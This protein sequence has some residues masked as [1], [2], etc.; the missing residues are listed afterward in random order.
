M[1]TVSERARPSRVWVDHLHRLRWMIRGYIFLQGVAAFLSVLAILFWMSLFV[2]WAVEPS[3]FVRTLL[4]VIFCAIASVVV[5]RVAASRLLIPLSERS[6]ALL[7]ERHYHQLGERLVTVVE[8]SERDKE[9]IDYDPRMLASTREEVAQLLPDANVRM[10]FSLRPLLQT[11]VIAFA[12]LGSVAVFVLWQPGAARIWAD[13]SL[14]LGDSAWPHATK[15]DVEGFPP[16]P[17]GRRSVKVAKGDSLT[18]RAMA[19]LN[20]SVPQSVEISYQ[21][22]GGGFNRP[23]M[24]RLNQAIPGR[25]AHQFYEYQFTDIQASVPF[26]VTAKGSGL[27]SKSDRV[28]GLLIEAV[29]SPDLTEISMHYEY[30]QYLGREAT[31]SQIRLSKPAPEGTGV[32]ILARSSKPLLK[33]SF[34][35]TDKETEVPW[36]SIE[37]HEHDSH[38]IELDLGSLRDD[39]RVSFQLVDTDGVTNQ[40]TIQ[41]LVRILP[42]EK[43]EVDVDLVGIGKAITPTA[44]LPIRGV[45]Q[46]DYGISKSWIEFSIDGAGPQEQEFS[47]PEN[48]QLDEARNLAFEL[49]DGQLHAGQILSLQIAA[50]DNCSLDPEFQIGKSDRFRLRVVSES[51]LRALLETRERILRRRFEAILTELHRTEDSFRRMLSDSEETSRSSSDLKNETE[52]NAP[53]SESENSRGDSPALTR[54]D[55]VRLLRIETAIQT[56]D[57]MQHETASVAEEFERILAELKNNKVAFFEEL[58]RRI[59]GGIVVPLNQIVEQQFS[60]F[61]RDLK[62]LRHALEDQQSLFAEIE[63]S[64]QQLSKIIRALENVLKNMLD[65]QKFNELLADLRKII[66]GHKQVSKQTQEQRQLLEK[67]LKEQLKKGLLDGP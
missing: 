33:A 37:I 1:A 31:T 48:G 23:N 10:V 24:T 58:E 3:Q 11:F 29:E 26:S 51:D 38:A 60:Q 4:L 14:L 5:Y 52:E 62:R 13:R 47:L 61:D 63:S 65:L 25:D 35:K 9:N 20:W 6:L 21:A 56:S 12:V 66:H 54:A 53:E 36:E 64:Q 16:D 49:A 46:D 15:I 7:L 19:D 34:R 8:L 44:A 55:S 67:Q 28:D 50:A 45:V 32:R 18:V 59:G 2:D 57:R 41:V 17:L 27:F 30:P 40:K 22:D 42:D 39:T 43:P